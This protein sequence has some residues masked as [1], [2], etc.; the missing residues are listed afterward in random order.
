[1]RSCELYEFL[2]YTIKSQKKRRRERGKLATFT[3]IAPKT[4][5]DDFEKLRQFV[6]LYA[7]EKL[8]EFVEVKGKAKQVDLRG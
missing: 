2:Y 3:Q 1:M 5:L 4:L 7:F 8:Y 6:K